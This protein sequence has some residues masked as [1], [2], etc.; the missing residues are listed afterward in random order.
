MPVL[1]RMM[2]RKAALRQLSALSP[3]LYRISDFAMLRLTLLALLP[4][5]GGILL[6]LARA[7]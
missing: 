6:M 5:A 7:R 1:R 2:R 3:Y 4:Q